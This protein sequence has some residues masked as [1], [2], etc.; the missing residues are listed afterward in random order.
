VACLVVNWVR[1]LRL[2]VRRAAAA[3]VSKAHLV[4]VGVV[5]GTPGASTAVASLM[6]V[7]LHI[8]QHCIRHAMHEQR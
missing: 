6:P 8:Q 1:A 2:L 4:V 7:A 3:A 5:P